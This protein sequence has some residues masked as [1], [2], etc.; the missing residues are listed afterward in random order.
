MPALEL[1]RLQMPAQHLK[2]LQALLAQH[3]PH[4]EVWAYGSRVNGGSHE[5]SDLD[6]VLRH[7][8]DLAQDVEDWFDLKEA[9]Q[10]SSLPMLVEVHLWSRLP[11]T[12]HTNIKAGYVVVQAGK[13]L[14]HG[15]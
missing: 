6:L 13:D 5:G 8:R 4:A 11:Q 15:E 14:G 2:T 9:L 7:S 1:S 3:V 12:F 10:A